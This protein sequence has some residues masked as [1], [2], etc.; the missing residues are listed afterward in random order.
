MKIIE[1]L[2]KIKYLKKKIQDLHEKI[3]RFSADNDCDAPTYKDQTKQITEWTQSCSD[4]LKELSTLQF[5][6]Q[7]T[8]INTE[9]SIELNG[10]VVTKSIYEWVHRVRDLIRDDL[11]TWKSLNSSGMNEARKYNLPGTSVEY[12]VKRRLYFDP[13]IKDKKI[14]ELNLETSLIHSKLEITN[15]ITNLLD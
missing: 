2:K 11:E 15:A 8:N 6:I 14:E 12:I 9:I 5:R 3:N 1:G 7:K 10:N 4:L 13:V